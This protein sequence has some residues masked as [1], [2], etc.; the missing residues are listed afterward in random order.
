VNIAKLSWNQQALYQ[1]KACS[2]EGLIE[3]GRSG[4]YIAFLAKL[5]I[6]SRC[7]SS[8]WRPSVRSSRFI[9]EAGSWIG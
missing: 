9:L 2:D 8:S 4:S 5:G 6:L 3:L 1:Q 7:W